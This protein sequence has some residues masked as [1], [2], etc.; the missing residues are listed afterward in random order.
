MSALTFNL[1]DGFTEAVVRGYRS[2]ILTSADYSNLGQ[3]DGLEDMRMHLAVTDYGN[4]LQ[5]EPS[6][7]QT[8][9]IS[10]KCTEKLVDEFNYIRCNAS[11]ELAKFLDYITY[12][13]LAHPCPNSSLSA[14]L[15]AKLRHEEPAD[16]FRRSVLGRVSLLIHTILALP[17]TGW[18]GPCRRADVR[19][20]TLRRIHV[21]DSCYC[22]RVTAM[23][24]TT[25]LLCLLNAIRACRAGT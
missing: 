4:F 25:F 18:Y 7:L 19:D 5:N 11:G 2:G 23:F 16:C 3:C 17:C 14:P 22:C 20:V 10:E 8:M 13:C 24:A 6:P 15:P 21:G 9:T 12:G 1:D